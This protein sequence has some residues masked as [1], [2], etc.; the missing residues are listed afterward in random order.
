MPQ[1]ERLSEKMN[2]WP[3][4]EA[5]RATV[6][7]GQ[8]GKFVDNLSAE[9][10]ILRYTSKPE[11]GIYFMTLRISQAEFLHI[12]WIFSCFSVWNRQPAFCLSVTGF[13]KKS[14]FRF[15]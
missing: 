13:C 5:S 11:R 12:L 7:T 10:I 6:T 14:V 8:L 3:R 4:S 15:P 9:G 1:A 2:S